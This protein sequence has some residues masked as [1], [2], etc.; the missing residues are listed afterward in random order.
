[1]YLNATIG[2]RRHRY[3][4]KITPNIILD[5]DRVSK[6]VYRFSYFYLTDE[7]DSNLSCIRSTLSKYL[8]MIKTIRYCRVRMTTEEAMSEILPPEVKILVIVE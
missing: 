6:F 5:R 2:T 8:A 4:K 3:T 1:M 7:S